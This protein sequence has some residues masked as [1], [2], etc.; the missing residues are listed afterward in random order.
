VRAA[1]AA[2]ITKTKEQI[3]KNKTTFNLSEDGQYFYVRIGN[4][5]DLISVNL[6]KHQLGIPYTKKDGTHV[7]AE[8]IEAQRAESQKSL[9]LIRQ[10]NQ[11][12]D[13]IRESRKRK[14]S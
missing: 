9:E 7:S 1:K 6:V 5:T 12:D 8:E 3:M 10:R 11:L 13:Q 2:G 14:V 4:Q